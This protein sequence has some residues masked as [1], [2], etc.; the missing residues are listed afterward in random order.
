MWNPIEF[1]R[2]IQF[3]AIAAASVGFTSAP[4]SAGCHLVDCVEDVYIKD[5]EV[6]NIGCEQLWILR[7]SIFKD[8][9]YC[10][11]TP[12]AINWF[13]NAGCRHDSLAGLPLNDFKRHNIGVLQAAERRRGCKS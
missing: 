8:A 9:G 10:F 7:N 12:R 11:K 3:I 6:R 13:G 4:A 2:A 1:R 5:R